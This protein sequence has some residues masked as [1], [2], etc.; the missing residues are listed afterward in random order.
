MCRKLAFIFLLTASLATAGDVSTVLFHDPALDTL[1]GQLGNVDADLN[2]FMNKNGEWMTMEQVARFANTFLQGGTNVPLDNTGTNFITFESPE[3]KAAKTSYFALTN[4]APFTS[5]FTNLLVRP[6]LSGILDTNFLAGT[7]DGNTP[8]PPAG[9]LVSLPNGE[10]RSLNLNLLCSG[11]YFD[12]A[13][14][15]LCTTGSACRAF[16]MA[17]TWLGFFIAAKS[18]L[19]DQCSILL[20]QN[21]VQGSTQEVLGNNASLP[22]GLAYSIL[23]TA[24]L[25]SLIG[26]F[27][28]TDSFVGNS[29]TSFTSI[30]PI[31]YQCASAFPA[32]DVLTT[33]VPVEELFLSFLSWVAFRYLYG[34]PVFLVVRSIMKFLIA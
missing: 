2:G 25:V 32:W 3:A 7:S 33:F 19:Q 9:I 4:S 28:S 24:A 5:A 8:L 16:I 23:I 14:L 18:W 12:S 22:V 13:L 26:Y 20:G 30:K 6:F 11:S 27:A 34:W 29:F 17:L 10:S 15:N 31:F 21:Q 1:N